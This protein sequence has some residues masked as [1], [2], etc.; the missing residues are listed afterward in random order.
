MD[1]LPHRLRALRAVLATREHVL[2]T[3]VRGMRGERMLHELDETRPRILGGGRPLGQL[4]ELGE[5]VLE[6]CVYEL[7]LRR[8]V[9]VQRPHAQAG[10]T[11]DLVDGD[12]DALTR[13]ELA[14]A[15]DQPLA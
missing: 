4:D 13:K 3:A 5:R 2:E 12:I 6:H 7:F 11:C 15:R 10:V 9:A 14:R 1:T 8:E